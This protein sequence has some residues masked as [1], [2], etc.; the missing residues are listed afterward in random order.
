M[1]Q[2]LAVL[3]ATVLMTACAS[4]SSTRATPGAPDVQVSLAQAGIGSNGSLYPSGPINVLYQLTVV[5][6][7]NN[8]LTLKRLDMQS[9]GLGAYFIRTGPRPMNQTVVANGIST[10]GLSAWANARRGSLILNEPVTIRGV[11]TFDDGHGHTFTS[12]FTDTMNEFNRS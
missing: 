8:T 4:S 10:I 1:R 12:I 7:T 2:F 3:A 5:N 6:P 11:A 9:V